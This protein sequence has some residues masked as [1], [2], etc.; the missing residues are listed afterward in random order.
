VTILVGRN[1]KGRRAE[2]RRDEDISEL[3]AAVCARLHM[4][5]SA[6]AVKPNSF[7]RATAIS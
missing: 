3:A 1:G 7:D 6:S 5:S 4:F 2:V